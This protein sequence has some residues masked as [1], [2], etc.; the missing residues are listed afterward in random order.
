MC[1]HWAVIPEA[2]LWSFKFPVYQVVV[3][4]FGKALH[5]SPWM[6]ADQV[7]PGHAQEIGKPFG[8]GGNGEAMS[9]EGVPVS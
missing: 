3:V 9:A 5:A 2:G 8:K 7:L 4:E 1:H 6:G